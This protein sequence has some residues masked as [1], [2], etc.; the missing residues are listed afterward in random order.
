MDKETYADIFATTDWDGWCQQFI[1]ERKS[2]V[3]PV[4]TEQQEGRRE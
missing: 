4:A 3:D 2:N 1:E